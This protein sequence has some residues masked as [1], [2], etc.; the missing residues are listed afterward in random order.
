M[1]N[2]R[3]MDATVSTALENDVIRPVL[4][5]Y[6]DIASDPLICWTGPGLFSTGNSGDSILDDKTFIGLPPLMEV[7]DIVEDFGPGGPTSITVNGQ[8]LDEELLLQIVR[9]RYEWRGRKACLWMG[10]LATNNKVV[11]GNPIRIKT[12]VIS[13]LTTVRNLE[14][15]E[16]QITIDRDLGRARGSVYRWIDHPRFYP[17]DEWSSFIVSLANR[18]EDF[19]GEELLKDF[20][21]KPGV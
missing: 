12:G 7:G 1:S 16:V 15:A 17:Q 9:D 14:T 10:L 20:L 21:T 19:E 5:A 6:L 3:I 13:E 11:V 8:D 2:E 18:G 4:F